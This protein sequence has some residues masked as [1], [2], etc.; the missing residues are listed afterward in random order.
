MLTRRLAVGTAAA[1]VLAAATPSTAPS[2]TAAE[3][4]PTPDFRLTSPNLRPGGSVPEDHVLDGFGCAGGNIS[5][6]FD[7]EGAPAGARSYALTLFD[8]DAPTGSGWWHWVVFDIP[9]EVR[10]LPAGAGDP[11]GAAMPAVAIQSRTDFGA[12]GY[13]GPR[14]RPAPRRTGTSSRCTPSTSPRSGSTP[15]RP[16][17]WSVSPSV[18]TGSRWPPSNSASGDD[19]GP[20]A[21][22]E[23]APAVHHPERH[24]GIPSS[25]P[26]RAIRHRTRHPARVAQHRRDEVPRLR[27]G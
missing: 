18:S 26:H 5:P 20:R 24:P 4:T 21:E 19:R 6:A 23:A 13:G 10:A 16:A 17:P 7:W 12:P 11:E 1:R 25:V 14:P 27:S 15:T 8:P 9:A 22:A 3:A 2:A